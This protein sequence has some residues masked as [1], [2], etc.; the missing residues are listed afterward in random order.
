MYAV[1][2][3]PDALL[4]VFGD[5]VLAEFLRVRAGDLDGRYAWVRR[6]RERGGFTREFQDVLERMEA[7]R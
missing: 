1:Q 7:W 3:E 2:Q 6:A 4:R 5:P